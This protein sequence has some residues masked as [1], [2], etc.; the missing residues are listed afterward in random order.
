[1]VTS[2]TRDRTARLESLRGLSTI[3]RS[4]VNVAAM[5]HAREGLQPE[6]GCINMLN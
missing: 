6:S 4:R 1:M 2:T 5:N 3:R